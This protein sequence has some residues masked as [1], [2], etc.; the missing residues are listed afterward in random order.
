[1]TGLTVLMLGVAYP[2]AV[3]AVA[4]LAFPRAAAGSLVEV[5]GRVVGSA[6]IGQAWR[7]PRYFHGRPSAAGPAD[8]GGYDASASSGSN[9]GPTSRALIERLGAERAALQA[10]DGRDPP[11]D[12]TAASG[13][14]LDPH[15]S[16]EAARFQIPRVARARGL[17]P[18]QLE[19]LVARHVESRTLGLFG[20]PRVNVLELNLDLDGAP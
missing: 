13:S 2:L 6:L 7:S 8:R 9:L 4:R 1:L 3:T 15:I 18:E 10:S 12:L 11:T 17:S 19:A 16:P 14:G 5:E 20:A